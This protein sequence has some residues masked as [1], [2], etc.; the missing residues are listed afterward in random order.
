MDDAEPVKQLH[1]QNQELCFL[2]NLVFS[3]LSAL[4]TSLTS[5][6]FLRRLTSFS[7]AAP[8]QP[9]RKSPSTAPNRPPAPLHTL[10]IVK[11][12]NLI[13]FIYHLFLSLFAVTLLHFSNLIHQS[14]SPLVSFWISTLLY[15]STLLFTLLQRFFRLCLCVKD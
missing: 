4:M 10:S 14:L 12:H 1:L 8:S 6:S 9:P 11:L 2:P 15:T 5:L 3:L 7:S 13:V